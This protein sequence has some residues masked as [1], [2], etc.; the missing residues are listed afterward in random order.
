VK[1]SD[2]DSL[3]NLV[4][5][6]V[7]SK[8]RL[9]KMV[10]TDS[11]EESRQLIMEMDR[12]VTD[13]QYQSMKIRLVPIDQVF[14]RFTRLI[15]DTSKSLGKE[16]NLEMDGAGIEL[17]RTVLD[18][19]TD[20]L[21]HILRNCVDHGLETPQERTAAGKSPMGN[22]HI[23]AYR[24]GDQIAIKIEDNG[25]GINLDRIKSKA[26][27]KGIISADD[28]KRM[29]KQEAIDLLGTPG[30][31]TAKEV[32]DISGRGVGMDVVIRQ[33]EEVGGSV[34]ISTEEG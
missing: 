7:I 28:A 18:A 27:E 21:L 3:V 20:P 24:V 33:V 11:S 2:L 13:L 16:V 34:K 8:M 19:I 6:L 9:E 14:S 10:G 30:L 4:G 29:S 1:M 26:V 31:S 25:R 5:E 17:D 32:T 23:S 12:L 15:R 22:I